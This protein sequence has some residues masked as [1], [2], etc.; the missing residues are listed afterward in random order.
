[1]ETNLSFHSTINLPKQ[2]RQFIVFQELPKF[3]VTIDADDRMN[4]GMNKKKKS[5]HIITRVPTRVNS[6]LDQTDTQYILTKLR[7][8]NHKP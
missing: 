2:S 1:M 7:S 8:E 3:N 5:V 6:L 4:N